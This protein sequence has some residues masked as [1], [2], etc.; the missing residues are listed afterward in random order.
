MF[1]R[2]QSKAVAFKC[3]DQSN[4]LN[5]VSIA[6]GM[7]QITSSTQG[8]YGLAGAVGIEL[9]SQAA[10]KNLQNIAVTV[11]VFIVNMGG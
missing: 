6:L 3:F 7:N 8:F 2:Y 10:D 4:D 11:K 1:L 9:F 5:G